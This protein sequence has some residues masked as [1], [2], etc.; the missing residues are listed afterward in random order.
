[1]SDNPPSLRN[2]PII[3]AESEMRWQDFVEPQPENAPEP[4]SPQAA[5]PAAPARPQRRRG[6]ARTSYMA[7]PA[8]AVSPDE[9]DP[10]LD[11][12]PVPHKAPRRNSIGPARQKAF[13]AELAAT[14][15]VAEAARH[16]GASLEALYKLRKRPGAEGFDAAWEAAVD[17]GIARLED[18]ALSRAI[19]GEERLV[20]SGGKVLGTEVRHNEALVMFFLRSRRPARYGADVQPGHPLYERIRAEVLA[21]ERAGQARSEEEVY[22]AIDAKLAAYRRREEAARVLLLEDGVKVDGVSGSATAS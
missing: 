11:F 4:G 3:Y 10:L 7:A 21:V 13:I 1:M 9:D 19:A 5:K 17:R 22:A 2:R 6:R 16:I 14:G 20:V 12:A 15:I 18:G 8:A